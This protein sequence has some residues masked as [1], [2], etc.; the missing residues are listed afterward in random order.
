MLIQYL[1]FLPVPKS[2]I[3]ELNKDHDK[4]VP[5]KLTAI[6]PTYVRSETKSELYRPWC[7]KYICEAHWT[8]H[9]IKDYLNI[10]KDTNGVRFRLNYIIDPGGDN[11]LTKFYNDDKEEIDSIKIEPFRWHLFDTTVYHN[12]VNL[13]PGRIRFALTAAILFMPGTEPWRNRENPPKTDS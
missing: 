13:E 10:H 5:T 9:T 3:E 1:N 7:N 12:V 11:V 4:F 8:T 2:I 6:Y